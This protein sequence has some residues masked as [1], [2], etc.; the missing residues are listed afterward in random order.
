MWFGV[1]FLLPV[2]CLFPAVVPTEDPGLH[3]GSCPMLSLLQFLS[4]QHMGLC[5][6]PQRLSMEPPALCSLRFCKY[7]QEE[8][9]SVLFTRVLAFRLYFYFCRPELLS[10]A[11]L[12][13]LP[14]WSDSSSVLRLCACCLSLL[15]DT[16]SC[17]KS[18]EQSSSSVPVPLRVHP[19]LG[20]CLLRL[21]LPWQ[22]SEDFR[23]FGGGILA[24]LVLL[25]IS[26]LP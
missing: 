5:C 21:W 14:V 24:F 11:L 3:L 13:F 16:Q 8:S 4:P 20:S 2:V 17:P 9:D 25:G 19:S 1:R 18:E 12:S 22:L 26:G 10:K 6:A 23:L 15:P 7:L